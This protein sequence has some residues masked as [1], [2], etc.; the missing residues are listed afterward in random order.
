MSY[1]KKYE[2]VISIA[3]NGGISQAAEELCIAQPTL[4][5]YIKKLE[6]ELGLEL[7]D[8]STIPIKVTP[9]GEQYI[10]AG[11]RMLD[12]DRQLQKQL[13]EIKSNK[14]SIIH[15]GISPSR[16]PYLMPAVI[17]AYKRK[18]SSG[19]VVIEE[20]TTGELIKL[21]AQGKLDLIISLLDEDTESFEKIDLFEEDI[22][23]A[24]AKNSK[25]CL[26]SALDVLCS[27]PLINVGKGL[28]MW[29]TMQELTEEL[30]IKTPEIECQ[31]IESA[32]ALVKRGLGAMLVPSYIERFGTEEQNRNVSFFSLTDETLK[33]SA[34]YKR[35]VCLFY[36]KEQFLTQAEK[37]F[38]NCVGEE[39][40]R[41]E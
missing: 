33:R 18:N 21:L 31:S 28:V 15:V 12:L 10:E 38:I 36:R 37:E 27:S 25:Y 6:E 14:N 22:L 26:E 32:F 35:K 41:A 7:F 3:H 2:Y 20:K 9:A 34:V 40:R 29:R 11:R 24:V 19:R 30:G 16:S 17:E 39:V 13:Q 8:R 1:L 4:S 5:K 23:L